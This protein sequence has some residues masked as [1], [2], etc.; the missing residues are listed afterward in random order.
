MS[1]MRSASSS[2]SNLYLRQIDRA[3]ADVI[4]QAARRGDQD[5]DAANQLLL[6]RVDADAAEDDGGFQ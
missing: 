3:L 1:S 4:E 6:L 5:I 2:T